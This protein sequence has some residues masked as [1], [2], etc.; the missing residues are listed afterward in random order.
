MPASQVLLC[1]SV[2]SMRS[3]NRSLLGRVLA[4]RCCST[5]VAASAIPAAIAA[6]AEMRIE[7]ILRAEPGTDLLR[8][9]APSGYRLTGLRA[10]VDALSAQHDPVVQLVG[11]VPPPYRSRHSCDPG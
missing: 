8:I 5:P 10:A 9:Q 1:A 3:E 7:P 4:A 6:N 11:H 2:A